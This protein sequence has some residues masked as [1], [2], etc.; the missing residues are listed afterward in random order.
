MVVLDSNLVVDRTYLPE[1]QQGRDWEVSVE[2]VYAKY[3]WWGQHPLQHTTQDHGQSDI[4][5]LQS[6]RLHGP[7]GQPVTVLKHLLGKK[8]IFLYFNGISHIIFW[9]ITSYPFTDHHWI[10]MHLLQFITYIFPIVIFLQ[11]EEFKLPQHSFVLRCSG[12]LIIFVA[13]CWTHSSTSMSL[14]H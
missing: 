8:N 7:F 6:W 13:I 9:P 3:P 14:L 12:P 10:L 2:E 4:I 11:T 1:S 5:H